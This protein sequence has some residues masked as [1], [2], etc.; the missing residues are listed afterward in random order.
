M[1]LVPGLDLR[2]GQRHRCA[3]TNAIKGDLLDVGRDVV[4]A[5]VDEGGPG[6]DDHRSHVRR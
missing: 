5:G 4:E 2:R 3:M 1:E 6:V